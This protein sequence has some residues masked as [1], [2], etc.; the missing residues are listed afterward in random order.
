MNKSRLHTI[1]DCVD[2]L[3]A[4]LIRIHA[5]YVARLDDHDSNHNLV[6]EMK[7]AVGRL[8]ELLG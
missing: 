7:V 1:A 5:P 8:K 6:K 4:N 2:L 3:E